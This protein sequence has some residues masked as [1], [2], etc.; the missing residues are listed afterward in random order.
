M[1]RNT[2]RPLVRRRFSSQH[3]EVAEPDY[4]TGY[5]RPPKHAQFRPGKSGNPRGRPRG[6][7]SLQDIVKDVLFEKMEV[8]VGE[9]THRMASVNAL[10]RTAMN[11]ALKG[12]Y[13]FLMAVIAFIRLSGLSDIGGEAVVAET[14]IGADEAILADFLSR[15][16]F[17][18]ESRTPSLAKSP[19]KQRNP[20]R[21][22]R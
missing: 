15:Q 12:D 17:V 8:R 3:D 1:R 22:R 7:A 18:L 16:G 6:R 4:P 14:D 20:S 5:G 21:R 9:R 11:R 2:Q 19:A 10:M 13:K